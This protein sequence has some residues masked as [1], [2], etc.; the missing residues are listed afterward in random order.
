VEC[1]VARCSSRFTFDGES[2]SRD[3]IVQ[4]FDQQDGVS[5]FRAWVANRLV[6]EWA[7]DDRVP[8][9]KVDGSSSSRR[10]IPGIP[11]RHGDE[12]R[13]EGAPDGAETA[14]LDYIEIRPS[15][16]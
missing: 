4:Y 6:A 9:R 8:T 7:A 13:I 15:E 11:L 3:L 16:D 2:G 5:H 1:N 14:A 10:V 12:I